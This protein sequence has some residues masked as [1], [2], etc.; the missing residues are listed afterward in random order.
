MTRAIKR[1][2]TAPVPIAKALCQAAVVLALGMGS[3]LS[4]AVA[5][6]WAGPAESSQPVSHD[7]SAPPSARPQESTGPIAVNAPQRLQPQWPQPELSLNDNRKVDYFVLANQLPVLLISDPNAEKAA[8]AMDVNVGSGE[9]P[10]ERPGLAHFLEHMLFLGTQK[11]PNAQEYQAYIQQHGGSHN[12]YT[13]L[14]H[15]NYFFDINAEH[16]AGALDRFAQFFIKPLFNEEFVDRER[17]AVHSEFRAKYS[18]EFRRQEDVMRQLVTPGHAMSRFRTGNLDSLHNENG[19]LRKAL[20]KFYSQ[21]YAA[22]NM[23]L[24][25]IG[26]ETLPQLRAMVKPLFG[27]IKD[28]PVE[29]PKNDKPLFPEKLLPASIDI[30]PNTEVRTVSYLFPVPKNNYWM[31]KPLSYLGFIL[32]HEGEGSLAWLLKEQGWAESLGA[33]QGLGWREGDTFNI[34][35]ELTPKGLANVDTIDSLL[36]SYIHALQ[37]DGI[38]A[39]RFD[40]IK[41]LGEIDFNFKERSGAMR[42]ASHLATKMQLIESRDLFAV[43]YRLGE[44]DKPLIQSFAKHLNE[45]NVLRILT[46]PS[47]STNEQ[48]ALYQV[49][50]K[51][52]KDYQPVKLDPSKDDAYKAL[53]AQSA[54]PAKNPFVPESLALVEGHDEQPKAIIESSRFNAWHVTNTAFSVPRATVRV[55]LKSA[56]VEQSVDNAAQIR[57]LADAIEADLNPVTYQAA[58]AGA[59]FRVSATSRGIDF[60]FSGYS[61]SIEPL[62]NYI[63]K[64]MKAYGKGKGILDEISRLDSIQSALV[65][66]YRNDVKDTPYRQMMGQLAATIYQPYWTPT[67]MADAIAAVKPKALAD[68]TEALLEQSEVTV[69]SAGNLEA[70]QAKRLAKKLKRALVDGRSFNSKVKAQV[71]KIQ[72]VHAVDVA[73][74]HQDNAVMLYL[75]GADDSLTEQ[76]ALQL[77]AQTLSTPFYYQLRTEQQLGYIVF[78][79]YYP[80]R[81]MPGA[82][83]VVQSPQTGVVEIKQAIDRFL[84]GVKPDFDT[85]FHVHQLAL[86]GQL[87]EK[88]KNLNELVGDYWQ[89]LNN[90]DFDFNQKAE[91]IR[92]VESWEVKEFKEW[93]AQFLRKTDQKQLIFYSQNAQAEAP[94]PAFS[95]YPH[96]T[97]STHYKA[98]TPAVTYP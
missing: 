89:S 13:S 41:S 34:A 81:D 4:P 98:K 95:L 17:N 15:T 31:K 90:G 8:A 53:L 16:L 39:W 38:D 59:N 10:L 36:F 70:K 64:Q 47:L 1:N 24:V 23:R 29:T 50:Y 85:E 60:V 9:D 5:S 27:A 14:M 19:E 74:E 42:E 58:M 44:F 46:A 96:I 35:I 54:L 21:H 91:L 77:F 66:R 87:S 11:Y 71:S 40:E 79:S 62:L 68:F 32:G 37:K 6:E 82:V 48:T 97:D 57:L 18:T 25:V 76:A 2:Y 56:L 55:R 78:G 86:V 3:M 45:D 75:Q 49:P 63:V 67:Q 30:V 28:F 73:A 22:S 80:V 65:R 72:G 51:V 92:A 69:L 94:K 52:H 7:G 61:D 20:V 26:K 83:F 84:A 93:Y 12:A 33:G 43:D 88:P